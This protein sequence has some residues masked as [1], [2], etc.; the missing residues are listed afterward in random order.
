MKNINLLGYSGCQLDVISLTSGEVFIKK[1][2]KNKD[3]NNRLKMQ[4]KK[5]IKYHGSFKSCKVYYDFYEND[6]Y[7]FIME[8]I[9]GVN[10]GEGLKS[11]SISEIN[12]FVEMFF[13]EIQINNEFD[14]NAS[15][16]L[17]N[18]ILSVSLQ[19]GDIKKID[20]YL[21]L[22]HKHSWS[23]IIKSNCHGD[24]TLENIIYKNGDYYLIDFLD[25]F[26][27]SWMIDVA[28]LLQDTELFWCY[29]EKTINND[30]Y[31]KLLYMRNLIIDRI[32]LFKNG[33]EIL[34]EIYHILMLNLL[35][36]LPYVKDAL[37]EKFIMTKLEYVYN[38]IAHVK[39]GEFYSEYFN[40][41]VRR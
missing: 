41:S 23:Y 30:V 34:C 29:R 14:K 38:R 32:L 35:R 19:I 9:D 26:Y 36:I 39:G 6:L 17:K 37:T 24:L 7:S 2:S 22:L 27:D 12:N 21:S 18:K 33:Y 5:Q 4:L 13:D 31:T 20:K 40:Y 1:T 10:L 15:K 16:I 25:S 8:Y 11:I 3:Y 28:K